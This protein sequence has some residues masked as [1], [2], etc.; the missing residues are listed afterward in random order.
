MHLSNESLR[1]CCVD[2]FTAIQRH[3]PIRHCCAKLQW[4]PTVQA[5]AHRTSHHSLLTIINVYRWPVVSCGSA[6]GR[7]HTLAGPSGMEASPSCAAALG[8][9]CRSTTPPGSSQLTPAEQVSSQ[10]Q[11]ARHSSP[12]STAGQTGAWRQA[13]AAVPPAVPPAPPPATASPLD[14]QLLKQPF[15]SVGSSMTWRPEAVGASDDGIGQH[16]M[17]VQPCCP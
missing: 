15:A 4:F 11:A 7:Q 12:D 17:L 16:S 2:A 5:D 9:G 3:T 8:Q 10:T 6:G 14:Q 1:C 13:D